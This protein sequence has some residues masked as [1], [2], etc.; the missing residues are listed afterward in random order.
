M[1]PSDIPIH[2]F[3]SM[4]VKDAAYQ[5][6]LADLYRQRDVVDFQILQAENEQKKM[7]KFMKAE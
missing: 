4:S 2:A 3:A 6:V 5:I 7:S 1:R